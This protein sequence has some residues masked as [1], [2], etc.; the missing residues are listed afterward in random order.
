MLMTALVIVISVE[1]LTAVMT[2]IHAVHDDCDFC[3]VLDACDTS[4]NLP[5]PNKFPKQSINY[6][7]RTFVAVFPKPESASNIT[8]PAQIFW[9]RV[10]PIW[11]KNTASR[12]GYRYGVAELDM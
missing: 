2:D 8:D 11:F 6:K 10:Y 5:V 3:H 12:W 7:Y 9:I 4:E 1:S